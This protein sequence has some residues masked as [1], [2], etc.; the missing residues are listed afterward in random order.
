MRRRVVV[1]SA[2]AGVVAAGAALFFGLVGFPGHG[3]GGDSASSDAGC[4]STNLPPGVS[5]RLLEA[6]DPCY[7]FEGYRVTKLLGF[8]VDP[9]GRSLDQPLIDYA[10]NAVATWKTAT[11]LDLP[12]SVGDPCPGV[13]L[14]IGSGVNVIGWGPLAGEEI[15]YTTVKYREGVAEDA[16]I[17]FESSPDRL[18]ET[19]LDAVAL[20]EFG[21]VLGLQHQTDPDSIMVPATD[22]PD[23][24]VLSPRDIAAV[25]L[26]YR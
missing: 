2:V 5:A 12:V 4:A 26:L 16:V 19:C 3:G 7:R 18:P 15:G 25:Q 17:T 13:R 6:T 23:D 10:R 8:C 22:C 24:P 21:H 14:K 11:G 20:H 9:D 1:L